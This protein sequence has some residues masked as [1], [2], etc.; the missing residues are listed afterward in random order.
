ML[1]KAC[2]DPSRCKGVI[3]LNEH[4]YR[5]WVVIIAAGTLLVTII[6]LW[7]GG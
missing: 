4:D 5:K 7:I 3:E 2:R 6:H 1:P